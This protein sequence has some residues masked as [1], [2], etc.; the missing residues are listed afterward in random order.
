MEEKKVKK[1][2]KIGM[3]VGILIWL[4]IGF[5]CG[6]LIVSYLDA[7]SALELPIGPYMLRIIGLLLIMYAALFLQIIFHEGGHLVFGLLTG[8]GFSSFRIGNFMWLKEN[9]K[10]KY[11]RLSVAGTGGQCL[12]TPPDMINGKFPVVLYNLG[13]SILNMVIS[14]FAL[15]GCW[16]IGRGSLL[17]VFCSFLSVMGIAFA[18]L[19]GI[20]LRTAAVDNDGYNA[21]SLGKTPEALHA[22]WIQLKV[23]EQISRGVRLKDMP[24]EWFAMPT[25]EGMSYGMTATIAV[26]RANRLMDMHMFSEE[27][28]L[29]D[30]LF[31]METGMIGIH[32]SLLICD[33]IFCELMEENNPDMVSGLRNKNQI[34]FMK[35]MKKYP[36]V[37]RTEYT[38]ALLAEKDEAKTQK[39]KEQFEKCVKTYPYPS[40]IE[41]ERELMEIADEKYRNQCTDGINEK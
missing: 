23:N 37:I 25:E 34:K 32:R 20:P 28:E 4:G 13:G 10:I 14:V 12:M 40:D 31:G 24:E 1:S 26:F 38:Y 22:F 8:Y 11:C 18:L 5:I 33:R 21:F 3:I 16:M 35:Q 29:I 17:S 6:M 41:S 15:T 36:S 9:G 7:V 39:I 30:R 19:N 2:P 27:T